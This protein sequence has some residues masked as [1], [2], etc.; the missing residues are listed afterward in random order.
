MK[1]SLLVLAVAIAACG[2]GGGSA[3]DTTTTDGGG[4]TADSGSPGIKGLMTIT[5]TPADQ[6]LTIDGA[7]VTSQYHAMGTFMD[8]TSRDITAQCTFYLRDVALG[9]FTGAM[10]TSGTDVGGV[11]TVS[12]SAGSLTGTTQLTLILKQ[13][14]NDPGSTGLPA[15]PGSKF[16]GT[17]NAGRAPDLVY[18]NDGVLLPPN[19][20]KLEF[21]F[22]PG[23][24]NTLFELAFTNAVTDVRVYARCTTL[25]AG[26][27]ITTSDQLWRWI[28]KTNAG[29]APLMVTVR[30]TDDTGTAVGAS[31]PV[32]ISFSKDLV[33]GGL[34]YWTTSG[35]TAIMRY[36]FGS[37]TQTTPEKYVGPEVAGNGCIGCHALSRDGMKIVLQAGTNT[38]GPDGRL[39][40]LDVKTKNPIV[41]F[42]SPPKSTFESWNT[43][44]S[45]FV[46][47]YADSGATDYNL[48][49]IDGMTG[50]KAGSLTGTG[51]ATNPATHPDWSP[52]G[53]KIAYTKVGQKSANFTLQRFGG[54]AI[55][56]VTQTGTTWGAP[57]EI[58]PAASGKNHYYPT[59]SPDNNFLLYDES[60]CAGATGCIQN[61]GQP[62]CGCDADTDG[63]AHV[64]AVAPTAGARPIDLVKLNAPGK[65]DSG[66][67]S[68]TNSFPKWSPF[69]FHRTGELGT[70]LQWVTFSSTRN[71][72]LRT[73]P[74]PANGGTGEATSG[75]LIWMTAI[76]PDKVE[77][78]MDGS[79][80]AF[81]LPFQDVTTSNHIAQWTTKVVTIN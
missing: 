22:K 76:D 61:P 79:Y 44:G 59:F 17:V 38:A 71:Y 67:T 77:G 27:L 74:A 53:T 4:Q 10:F 32:S 70:R 52:D 35:Q 46:G 16:G 49:L 12:A 11:T 66:A 5:V 7:A 72:G 43:T 62:A 78:G 50:M 60:T 9:G 15:D 13:K 14:M 20:G 2:P 68:L 3:D 8:G 36:D 55:E 26:C 65:M 45:Q 75:T 28:S 73:P 42:A 18:P 33:T 54:G 1:R 81:C 34:Y 58:V 41:A 39:A 24:Q 69:I 37:T 80:P 64:F 56:L 48:F 57:T 30:G 19:L 29:G 23:T 31:T 47:A 6:T 25:G 40:L 21:H 63:S 51:T